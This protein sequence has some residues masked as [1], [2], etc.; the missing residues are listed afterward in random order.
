MELEEI[1]IVFPK[2]MNHSNRFN[3]KLIPVV[4]KQTEIS[5]NSTWKITFQNYFALF[6]KL[7]LI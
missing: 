2:C 3:D 5:S 1:E 4:R 7:S 6:F